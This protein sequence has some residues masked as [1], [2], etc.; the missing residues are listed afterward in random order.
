MPYVS[1]VAT[2]MLAVLTSSMEMI[3][4]TF[5]VKKMKLS[6]LYIFLEYA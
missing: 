3:V 2:E 5:L 6:G 1:T 4:L